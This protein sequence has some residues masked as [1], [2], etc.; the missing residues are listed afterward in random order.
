MSYR[1]SLFGPFV[2][3]YGAN[4][5]QIRQSGLDS[6]LGFKAKAL[7]SFK[8]VPSSDLPR[9]PTTS[10]AMCTYHAMPG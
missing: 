8:D 10:L 4:S 6:G 1:C 5:A 2:E 9:R 7:K 3:V